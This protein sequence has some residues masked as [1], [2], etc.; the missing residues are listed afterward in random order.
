MPSTELFVRLLLPIVFITFSSLF[1]FSFL[2]LK[3]FVRLNRAL[4]TYTPS[5]MYIHYTWGLLGQKLIIVIFRASS[6][7]HMHFSSYVPFLR[8][9]MHRYDL[10]FGQVGLPGSYAYALRSR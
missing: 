10:S 8:H 3:L 7:S 4:V 5:N 1:A 9:Y 6:S 2:A